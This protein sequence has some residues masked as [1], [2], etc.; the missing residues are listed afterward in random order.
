MSR[1]LKKKGKN[2]R[3]KKITNAKYDALFKRDHKQKDEED[4]EKITDE[5]TQREED[6]PTVTMTKTA[7][8][9]LEITTKFASVLTILISA[10]TFFMLWATEQ[11]LERY[12]IGESMRKSL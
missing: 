3:Q 11:Y 1:K 4:R 7:N 5:T 9:W 10:Y 8:N 12:H 6:N 2:N